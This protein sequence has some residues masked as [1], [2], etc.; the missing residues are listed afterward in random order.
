VRTFDLKIGDLTVDA[1]FEKPAFPALR[2]E[3]NRLLDVLYAAL[4]PFGIDL[5][6]VVFGQNG[7]L[8]DRNVYFGI[9]SLNAGVKVTVG[10]VEIG[11]NELTKI[12]FATADKVIKAVYTALEAADVGAKIGTYNLNLNAHGMVEGGNSQN[13]AKSFFA[14]VPS[15]LGPNISSGAVFYFGAHDRRVNMAL[16]ADSSTLVTDGLY[17]RIIFALDGKR[18]L[19]QDLPTVGRESIKQAFGALDLQLPNL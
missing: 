8:A 2:A 3:G 15:G 11:F 16:V 10:R 12:D 9:P 17:V 19:S 7:T 14:R 18:V 1:R 4:S 5:S 13:V 6:N